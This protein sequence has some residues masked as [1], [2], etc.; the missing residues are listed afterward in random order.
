MDRAESIASCDPGVVHP[1]AP[2]P[3]VCL[4]KMPTPL[5]ACN[6]GMSGEPEV[7][8]NPWPREVLS[9]SPQGSIVELWA[10]CPNLAFATP[11]DVH[12]HWPLSSDTL[13]TLCG[14][15][16]HA[17]GAMREL[18]LEQLARRLWLSPQ[19]TNSTPAPGEPLACSSSNQASN[20]WGHYCGDMAPTPMVVAPVE[21]GEVGEVGSLPAR[22]GFPPAATCA[23]RCGLSCLPLPRTTH[24]DVPAPPHPISGVGRLANRSRGTCAAADTCGREVREPTLLRVNVHSRYQH[25]GGTWR[26][27]KPVGPRN[28]FGCRPQSSAPSRPAGSLRIRTDDEKK[29]AVPSEF[30]W[31]VPTPKIGFIGPVG[32]PSVPVGSPATQLS[33]T[34]LGKRTTPNKKR[35]CDDAP[36][37]ASPPNAS[38]PNASP[39]CMSSGD[40]MSC[41]TAQVPAKRHKS[42]SFA[43]AARAANSAVAQSSPPTPTQF[44]V[45]PQI[46]VPLE[47]RVPAT[48]STPSARSTADHHA[49]T[50]MEEQVAPT[51][52]TVTPEAQIP[53][54]S[55]RVPAGL[56]WNVFA[57]TKPRTDAKPLVDGKSGT[58]S[59]T[60]QTGEQA[61]QVV[62]SVRMTGV[63]E[64]PWPTCTFTRRNGSA[65]ALV[66]HYRTS[67]TGEPYALCTL[68]ARPYKSKKGFDDHKRMH[69]RHG[70]GV[71]ATVAVE[72]HHAIPTVQEPTVPPKTPKTIGAFV[73]WLSTLPH[74]SSSSSEH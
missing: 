6:S 65:Q 44:A 40:S 43:Q 14:Y 54:D 1:N 31:T 59:S 7:T 3:Q 10:I 34:N 39:S 35:A 74:V 25:S 50:P 4:P 5:V 23:D 41:Q 70:P 38:P 47:I 45:A 36:P 55:N 28:P 48:I 29:S 68:C 9:V 57:G 52:V 24:L 63:V 22:V 51:P 15:G 18:F 11:P 37:N 60:V 30:D 67:H 56:H 58:R 17:T 19:A 2:P 62:R 12:R 71:P 61:L 66:R 46:R 33:I 49:S 72:F 16:K 27:Q 42:A 64:C 53:L 13:P 69:D 32:S 21:V 26:H 8:T 20:V 73:D